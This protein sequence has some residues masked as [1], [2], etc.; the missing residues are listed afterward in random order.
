M[1]PSR[2]S[3]KKLCT[4]YTSLPRN[5]LQGGLFSLRPFEVCPA[6]VVSTLTRSFSW[7]FFLFSFF[8]FSGSQVAFLPPCSNSLQSSSFTCTSSDRSDKA[9]TAPRSWP[10]QKRDSRTIIFPRLQNSKRK[11]LRR[12]CDKNPSTIFLVAVAELAERF[13]YRCITA[14]MRMLSLDISLTKAVTVS[15]RHF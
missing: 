8:F 3:V 5:F 2:Q 6:F 14:P 9:E 10:S 4:L 7:G 11:N 1:A 15:G 12:V 13:T